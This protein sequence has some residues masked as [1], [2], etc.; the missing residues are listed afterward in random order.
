MFGPYHHGSDGVV[1]LLGSWCLE[2]CRTGHSIASHSRGMRMACCWQQTPLF[3]P[4]CQLHCTVQELLS[5]KHVLV[6]DTG[7]SLFQIMKLRLPGKSRADRALVFFV[8]FAPF[9]NC[10]RRP[11]GLQECKSS[12]SRRPLCAGNSGVSI[13]VRLRAV[14]T[15]HG[16]RNPVNRS[17]P[18]LHAD[19]CG[20][21]MQAQ[22]AS[23][24]WSISAALGLATA[25]KAS[26]RRVVAVIGDGAFQMGPQVG[27]L[28]TNALVAYSQPKFDWSVSSGG[29]SD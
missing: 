4:D 6:S 27:H 22:Y 1:C 14:S 12:P 10:M 28:C 29:L 7:E 3:V 23:I 19:G 25:Y 9:V 18:V 26:G 24:G 21:Q 8:C 13:G 16:V 20:I 5:D 2:R 11:G 15:E 17:A